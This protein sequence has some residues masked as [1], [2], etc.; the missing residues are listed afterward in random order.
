MPRTKKRM[1]II[2]LDKEDKAEDMTRTLFKALDQ[3][4]G[5]GGAISQLHDQRQAY[6]E[7]K[8]KKLN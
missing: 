8:K 4:F 3:V 2:D 5:K 1:G 7:S 6:E